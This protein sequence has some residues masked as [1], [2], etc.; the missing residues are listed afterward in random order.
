MITKERDTNQV[1]ESGIIRNGHATW[2]AENH[3]M[4]TAVEV[5]KTCLELNRL[6]LEVNKTCLDV[7]KMCLEA[8]RRVKANA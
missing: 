4:T 6:C 5:N 8:K 3:Y 2:K 7:N 1:L